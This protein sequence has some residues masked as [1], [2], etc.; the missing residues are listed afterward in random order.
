MS[1]RY[2]HLANIT[3]TKEQ[4]LY[5]TI[6]AWCNYAENKQKHNAKS[7]NYIKWKCFHCSKE[8][9]VYYKCTNPKQLF[10]KDCR[11]KRVNRS[12]ILLRY[13]MMFK[14]HVRAIIIKNS[15]INNII[16]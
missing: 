16:R 6:D 12:G 2:N 5:S 8:I 15:N 3:P 7:S 1:K 11:P 14:N 9:K 10:C 4:L 13:L